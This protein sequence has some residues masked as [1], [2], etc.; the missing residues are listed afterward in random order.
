MT[1]TDIQSILELAKN[2]DLEIR[3]RVWPGLKSL[4]EADPQGHQDALAALVQ[5]HQALQA[6]PHQVRSVADMAAIRAYAPFTAFEMAIEPGYDDVANTAYLKAHQDIEHIAL[7]E[8][9]GPAVLDIVQS[10][11]WRSIALGACELGPDTSAALFGHPGLSALHALRVEDGWCTESFVSAMTNSAHLS[12]LRDLALTYGEGAPHFFPELARW[13]QWKRL[14]ALNMSFGGLEAQGIEAL[15]KL[16]APPDLQHLHL[17]SNEMG[18]EGLQALA[19]ST[20][21]DGLRVLMLGGDAFGG[22]NGIE[23]EGVVALSQ[24]PHLESLKVLD[25]AGNRIG[26]AGVKALAQAAL[27]NLETLRLG[28]NYMG[29]AGAIALIQSGNMPRLRHLDLGH[30]SLADKTIDALIGSAL[31]PQ[32]Q[33]VTLIWNQCSAEGLAALREANPHLCTESVWTS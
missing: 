19:S 12:S 15:A 11:S 27:P 7:F 32:L 1:S 24:S 28:S 17:G 20:W 23:D 6:M 25:L 29:D 9:K 18:D 30:N 22:T 14:R 16:P 21:L 10:G 3:K 8:L 2:A 31:L 26:D 13:P 33:T 5:H 4:H